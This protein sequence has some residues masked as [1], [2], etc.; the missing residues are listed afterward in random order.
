MRRQ[1]ICLLAVVLDPAGEDAPAL[2]KLLVQLPQVGCSL[3]TVQRCAPHS[4]IAGICDL[5]AN[6]GQQTHKQSRT[7]TEMVFIESCSQP[8]CSTACLRVHG[9][10]MQTC[11]V[12]AMQGPLERKKSVPAPPPVTPSMGP[13][14]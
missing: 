3:G 13:L 2:T 5:L 7:P 12:L 6:E 1:A 4:Y 8:T 11:N 14:L 10:S 9:F